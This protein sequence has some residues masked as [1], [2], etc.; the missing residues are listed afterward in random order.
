M[1]PRKKSNLQPLAAIIIIGDEILS[2]RTLDTNTQFLAKKLS[3]MGVNLC[4]VRVIPDKRQDIICAVKDLRDK[5]DYVF[6]SGGLGPTHDDITAESIAAAFNVSISVREDAKK[7]LATNYINGE[8]SLNQARL[9]MARIP[10]GAKLIHNPIS[11]APGFYLSNVYVMAGIPLIFQAMVESILPKLSG[12][13]PLLSITVKF[14]KP[15]GEIA[16]ALEKISTEFP[17]VSIGS[18]PFREQDLYG[19]N[20][21]ARHYEESVLTL[22]KMKLGELS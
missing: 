10:E 18:Y 1:N 15:E 12:G 14:L 17:E 3:N 2:G 21:V 5:Y 19:T 9:R 11:K 6:T 4:Q 20:V 13:K 8:L 22:V 16:L 7:M